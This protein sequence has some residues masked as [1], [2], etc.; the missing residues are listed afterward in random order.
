MN[1]DETDVAQRYDMAR[2]IPERTMHLWLDAIAQYIR[3]ARIR[4]VLDVGCG[5]GRFSV[6]LA[7]KFGAQVIGV[8]PSETM[9]AKAR[10]SIA[11]PFV[12]FRCG[13]A[14][15]LPVDN[16]SADFLFM[17]MVYHHINDHGQA[18]REFTRVLRAQGLLCIRNS[19]LDLLEKVPY[20]KYFPS[21]IDFYRKRMP[22]QSAVVNTMRL[23]GFSLLD[24]QV[25]EQQFATSLQAYF[26]KISQRALSDLVAITDAEFEAGI[27]RMREAL[28]G[29]E[30]SGPIIEP[31]DLFVFK[32]TPNESVHRI[33]QTIGSR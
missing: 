9:L 7:D 23:N 8:D 25:I 2:Q 29:S 19:T 27:Q 5:T 21:A 16:T 32:K 18:S 4:V 17:S 31:I 15:C 13:R 20:L 1:Y 3:A 14:E 26:H 22:S 10:T 24:H 12:S 30:G 28:K 33:S 11:H 6:A